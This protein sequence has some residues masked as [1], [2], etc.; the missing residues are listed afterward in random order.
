[1]AQAVVTR[2]R[3]SCGAISIDHKGNYLL[4]QVSFYV[5]TLRDL[6]IGGLLA[7][8]IDRMIRRLGWRRRSSVSVTGCSRF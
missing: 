3:Q 7:R 8:L 4:I 1:M 6:L 2:T 5:R